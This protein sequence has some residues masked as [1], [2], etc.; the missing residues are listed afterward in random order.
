MSPMSEVL[1][2]FQTDGY[3]VFRDV[4]DRPLVAEAAGH[5]DWLARAPSGCAPSS[6]ATP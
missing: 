4:L 3:A 6:W 1:D 2:R 5:V